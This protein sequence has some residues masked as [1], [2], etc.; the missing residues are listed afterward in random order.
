MVGGG[1][2]LGLRGVCQV[3]QGLLVQ[4]QLVHFHGKAPLVENLKSGGDYSRHFGEFRGKEAA[5]TSP[6]NTNP[7]LSAGRKWLLFF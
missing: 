3:P 5:S 4:L 1:P 7:G 2:K 6:L